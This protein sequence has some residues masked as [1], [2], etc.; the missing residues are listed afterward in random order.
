MS[1]I[2]FEREEKLE[3]S[4][5]KGEALVV[6]FVPIVEVEDRERRNGIAK[7]N[8]I[9]AIQRKRRSSIS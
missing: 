8:K 3:S 9:P 1:G 6:S 7:N 5:I 2:F 4:E